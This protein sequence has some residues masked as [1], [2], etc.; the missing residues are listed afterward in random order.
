MVFSQIE[1][2]LFSIVK[3]V[4]IKTL[5]SEKSRVEFLENMYDVDQ[6]IR[7]T[8]AYI[9]QTYGNNSLEYNEGVRKHKEM[10]S[11]L[12]IKT[13]E[14]LNLYSY[15]PIEMGSKACSTPQLIFHHA[16]NSGA[17]EIKIEFFQM[18]Y[19]AYKSNSIGQG[20]FWLYLFRMYQEIKR[21]EYS[22][23]TLREE[24]QIEAMISELGLL[25]QI[26]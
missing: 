17:V 22:D 16:W 20:F 19:L 15:P 6:G 18:F 9:Q 21:T 10:D 2:S 26:K 1:D 5:T 8:F 24:E 13:I 7:Q 25:I 23:Q 12:F 11:C 14:Y 4:N 3:A